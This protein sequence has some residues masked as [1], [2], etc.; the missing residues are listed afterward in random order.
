MKVMKLTEKSNYK[1]LHIKTELY[2]KVNPEESN[3]LIRASISISFVP[4]VVLQA[5]N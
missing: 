1:E 4:F 5:H 3:D 2:V